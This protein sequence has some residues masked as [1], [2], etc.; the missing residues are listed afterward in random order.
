MKSNWALVLLLS[1]TLIAC[2]QVSE[3]EINSDIAVIAEQMDTIE[4]LANAGVST[5]SLLT[6][7]LELFIDDPTL[8]PPGRSAIQGHD[9]ALAFYKNAFNN[10]EILNVVYE[11][12][13]I[14][15]EGNMAARRFIGT[16]KIQIRGQTDTLLS[17]SR[18][19]DVLQ[20]QPDGKWRIAWHGWESVDW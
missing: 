4:D 13:A 16:T 2:N 7:Y 15:I 18:Y 9:S 12:P 17:S 20:K 10:I 11:E 6:Q 19:I 8:L 1:C 5:D 3:N 14:L